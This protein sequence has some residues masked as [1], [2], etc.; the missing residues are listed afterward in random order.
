MN[1]VCSELSI[2]PQI[3][4]QLTFTDLKHVPVT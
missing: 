2:K 1:L 3:L 4:G